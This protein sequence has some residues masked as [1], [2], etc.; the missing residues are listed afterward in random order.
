M[1]SSSDKNARRPQKVAQKHNSQRNDHSQQFVNP[2]VILR[3][4]GL[5]KRRKINFGITERLPKTFSRLIL[6]R[7]SSILSWISARR[8]VSGRSSSSVS[9]F[10]FSNSSHFLEYTERQLWSSFFITSISFSDSRRAAK[11]DYRKNMPQPLQY[12]RTK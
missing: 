1:F 7:C 3:D 2:L 5:Q 10:T 8:W 12:G 9:F 11:D 4:R 6:V